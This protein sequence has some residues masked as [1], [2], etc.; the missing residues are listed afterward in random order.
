MKVRKNY[1]SFKR[2]QRSKRRQTEQ[3]NWTRGLL[4]I[5]LKKEEGENSNK[6]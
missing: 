5:E 1:N 4:L 3:L 6:Y 2:N